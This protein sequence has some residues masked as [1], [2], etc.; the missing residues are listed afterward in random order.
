MPKIDFNTRAF[1]SPVPKSLLQQLKGMNNSTLI[2]RVSQHH[3]TIPILAQKARISRSS[4][5]N[6]LFGKAVPIDEQGNWTKAAIRVSRALKSEPEVL[7][8]E[9]HDEI[10][11]ALAMPDETLFP[12]S[13][14][15][16]LH[17]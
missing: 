4:V 13:L 10:G 12:R 2:A 15:D 11:S 3:L 8:A 7:F 1:S 5:K 16:E 14:A 9:V 6:L 17:Q